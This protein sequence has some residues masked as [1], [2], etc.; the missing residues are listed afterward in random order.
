MN[1]DMK[2]HI[3]ETLLKGIRFDG[4]APDQYRDISV[5]LGVT[6]N[7]EGSARVRIGET[8]VIVGVKLSIEK[9]FPDTPEEGTMAVN[10]ELLPLSN[11][12]F[13]SG[14]P[15]I[16]AI[17]L[18]RV[19]DRGVRESKT[20]DT[21]QLCVEKGVKAWS[22]LIDICPI[23]DSGNLF[24]A[25]SLGTIAALFDTRFPK[26]DGTE[27]DYK[28]HTDKPLPMKIMPLAVTVYKIGKSLVVDPSTEEEEAADSR[29]TVCATDEGKICALQ[30]GGNQPLSIDELSQMVD[31]ALSKV[32]ELRKKAGVKK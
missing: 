27:I 29:I 4:R 25:S 22:I 19:V 11:P 23:N 8:D 17:E 9:P 7:A 14:P 6:K 28:E 15:G 26:F 20:I 21:K 31:L 30:K 2:Q 12:S 32:K 18:A 16:Q 13:E 10:V 24:D 1:K 5:E 3:E